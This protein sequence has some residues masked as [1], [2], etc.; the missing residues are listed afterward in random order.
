MLSPPHR[1]VSGPDFLPCL[2]TV[3]NVW[4]TAPAILSGNLTRVMPSS[5][6]RTGSVSA[7]SQENAHGRTLSIRFKHAVRLS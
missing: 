7:A 6:C 1:K 2:P 3:W 5:C 4:K